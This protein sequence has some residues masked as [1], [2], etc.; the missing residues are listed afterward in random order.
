MKKSRVICPAV[1][2]RVSNHRVANCERSILDG[3]TWEQ[4]GVDYYCSILETDSLCYP[5]RP[6]CLRRSLM[7]I[8]FYAY[9]NL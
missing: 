2:E 8:L 3:C 1:Q 6:H 5:I 4:H 9:F 7:R